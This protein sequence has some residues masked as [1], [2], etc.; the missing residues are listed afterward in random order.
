VKD[1]A[2]RLADVV[3]DRST[4][5]AIW[6]SGQGFA[7]DPETK[8]DW[9]YR[10]NPE[11]PPLVV[12]LEHGPDGKAVG[13][14]ALGSRRIRCGERTLRAGVLVD[15]FVLPEHRTLFPAVFL[16]KEVR[17]RA[18]GLHDIVF[19]LPNP[20]SLAAIRRIGY[21]PVGM[22]VRRAIVL[23]SSGY[24]GR[25][26][27]PW[28]AQ[29]A[30]P[31]VDRMRFALGEL[32]GAGP[33]G[34]QGAWL[35]RPDARFD[36]LWAR[37]ARPGVLMGS[38]DRAFLEWR[39]TDSP[40]K[41]QKFFTVTTEADQRLVGYAAC[42]FDG[43]ALHV[44]DFLVAPDVT[45]AWDALWRAL[46]RE[47]YREGCASMSLVFLGEERTQRDLEAAGWARRQEGPFYVEASAGCEA[48]MQENN[49]YFTDAD[50]DG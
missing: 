48:A 11:G 37:T 25:F 29:A 21:K 32:R 35:E 27:P 44:R 22:I 19:G 42:H 24:L 16:Q 36:D 38:R 5:L 20:K 2:V 46:K 8:F 49:W 50:E 13:V 43:T 12:I 31:V 3:A 6:R 9:Y 10:R 40:F 34:F 18:F 45:G 39:F 30:G 33:R 28:L 15:F 1:Y 41:P 17:R 4:I 14:A 23:R 7:V 47:A 26:A